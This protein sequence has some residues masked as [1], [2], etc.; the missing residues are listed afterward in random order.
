MN[1]VAS[2]VIPKFHE[3]CKGG[4]RFVFGLKVIREVRRL[5]QMAHTFY[6]HVLVSI[7]DFPVISET[8]EFSLYRTV[9]KNV[10]K[11]ENQ[12]SSF[13]E[14]V[15]SIA[16]PPANAL[17]R[18]PVWTALEEHGKRATLRRPLSYQHYGE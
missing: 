4:I 2:Y 5:R 7:T 18:Q 16:Y 17:Y 3:I 15:S 8:T 1:K 6:H 12:F 10:R 14:L 11:S 9:S 13:S